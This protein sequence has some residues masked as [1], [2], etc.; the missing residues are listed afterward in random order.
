MP[1]PMIM[2][3]IAADKAPLFD[4]CCMQD[5]WYRKVQQCLVNDSTSDPRPAIPVEQ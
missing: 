3:S 1:M 2:T 5:K 4:E